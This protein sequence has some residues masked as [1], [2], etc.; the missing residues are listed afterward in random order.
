MK[1][2]TTQQHRLP[3]AIWVCSLQIVAFTSNFFR[4]WCYGCF[5]HC[6]VWAVEDDDTTLKHAWNTWAKFLKSFENSESLFLLSCSCLCHCFFEFILLYFVFIV[7]SFL[8]DYVGITNF[9]P[10]KECN[11][12]LRNGMISFLDVRTGRKICS[13]LLWIYDDDISRRTRNQL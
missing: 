4:M 6:A 9:F 3:H 8:F 11:R 5:V 1:T 7:S 13:L 2:S 10:V 12:R